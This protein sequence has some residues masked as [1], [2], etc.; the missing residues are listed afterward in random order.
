MHNSISTVLDSSYSCTTRR[1]KH[2]IFIGIAP[3]VGK[4]YK[5]LEEAQQL[6]HQGKDVVIGLLEAHDRPAT[7]AKAQGMEIIPRKAI[8]QCGIIF[9]EMDTSTILARQP[10]L[11]L[12]DEL[13]HT[14]FSGVDYEYRYQDVEA[15]L[16]AGIDVYSTINIQD[17]ER[18][19][20]VVTKVP[21]IIVKATI[22]NRLFDEASQVV[23]VDV[24]PEKL[25]K[26]LQVGNIYPSET[27]EQSLQ[28][29][30]Q[31]QSLVMLRELALRCIADRVEQEGMREASR[32]SGNAIESA[33]PPCCIHERVLVCLSMAPHSIRLL[34]RGAD[35]ANRMN[36]PLY[37]LVIND[38]NRS[39][40]KSEALYINTCEQLC[41]DLR[42]K[43][44]QVKDDD[45]PTAI[46]RT[47]K[48][49]YITQIVLGKPGKS[50]WRKPLSR[51]LINQLIEHLADQAN[52]HILV[53]NP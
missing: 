29:V 16:A 8:T 36:A 21:G 10:Q 26:R 18:L 15:L 24:T 23:I 30:F 7:I 19:K 31:W 42:G 33:N 50:T 34:R 11:V 51:P 38:P 13:A 6:K 39:L 53:T 28:T 41:Q 48:T 17:L 46:A 32:L 45:I 40:S 20:D 22:P 2:K 14:N 43:F 35:L 3:G 27:V 1:G 52:L 9:H 25:Q 49:Y 37:A 44:L 12:V 4:T 47:A 5:M